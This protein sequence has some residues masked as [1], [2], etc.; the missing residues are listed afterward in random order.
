MYKI[1]NFINR[2]LALSKWSL[3]LISIFLFGCTGTSN[4]NGNTDVKSSINWEHLSSKNGDIPAPG[5]STQQTASL[6][7]DVDKDGVN[8]IIIGSRKV[9]PALLWYRRLADGWEKY[10]IEP[11]FLAVEAGGTFHDIDGDGDFDIV[12]GGDAS[13]NEI[14]WWENPYPD[15]IPDRPWQR[16]TIKNTGGNKHHDQIFGDFDGDKKAELVFWNQRDK[17]LCLAEIPQDPKTNNPWPYT[18][19]FIWE[20]DQDQHEGLA[21]DDIDGDGILD[22]VGGGGWFKFLTDGTFKMITIDKDQRF[23]RSASAQLKEGGT[24]EVVFVPGDKLG[25]IKWYEANGD[26]L[27]SESWIAHELLDSVVVHGHSLQLVDI[28]GDGLL[29]IFNAEMHTPGHKEEAACRIFFGDGNGGFTLSIVSTGIGNHESRIADLDGDGDLDILTK[30]YTWDTPRLDVW[31]NNGTLKSVE[32]LSLNKWERKL[33]EET[34]PHRAVYITAADLDG[35]H[36]KDIICGGWW[37][38]NPGKTGGSWKRSTIGTPLNNMAV[39]Y[40]FDDDG[41]IDV[42]GTKGEGANA[43]AEFV[44]AKNDGKGNFIIYNNIP[45]AEGDFLQGVAIGRFSSNGPIEVALS[46]H[47]AN[48]GVQMFTV[49]K[50]PVNGNWEWRKI[51]DFSQDEDLSMVD[52]NDDGYLDLYLGTSWLQNPGNAEASWNA[53]VIGEETTGLADRNA[54]YDFTGDGFLDAV[55]GL[56]FGTDILLFSSREDP[57]APWMRRIMAR[58]VGGGFSMDAA[59]MNGDGKID[60]ILGEHR[61]EPTNRLI[62]YENLGG[63]NWHPHIVDN[64]LNTEIDHHDG[65]QA[66]DMDGDGDMDIIS[67]GWYNPK[68]W[69]YE[70]KAKD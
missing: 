6:I 17:A 37:Y 5:P 45:L 48:N 46:W 53:H 25:P 27:N 28:N 65:S 43:S 59:D 60:V 57:T 69:L 62:I 38:R 30:P 36:K 41:F 33:I 39:V 68:I 20:E 7:L 12:F 21:S 19:I 40:D 14:W 9:G 24:P 34:L 70:N 16:R 23:T 11:E 35:D 10:A 31:L 15:Y 58:D 26:P 61:A 52:I 8:D 4:R 56:E 66:F 18:K 42:L 3:F 51:S 47:K 67:I 29:D 1:M 13:S 32:T 55:V 49:P 22:I 2:F 54:V 63:I 50:D 44:W 64:G